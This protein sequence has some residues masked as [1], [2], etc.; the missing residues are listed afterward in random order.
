MRV[1]NHIGMWGS[2]LAW[3]SASAIHQIYPMASTTAFLE[4]TV[5]SLLDLAW[6]PRLLQPKQNF[7]N[8]LVTVKWSTLTALWL[9]FN[10]QTLVYC[11]Q[12][13]LNLSYKF[14]VASVA[15]FELVMH[16][17]PNKTTLHIHLCGFPITHNM[18]QCT[19]CQHTDYH[20]TTNNRENFPQLQLLQSHDT[21][22]N[23]AHTLVIQNFRLSLVVS[24]PTFVMKKKKKKKKNFLANNISTKEKNAEK[25]V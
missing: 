14:L 23:L 11:D 6:S 2:E 12:L 24:N 17:F 13:H 8:H 5:L 16:K 15:Q 7:P 20:D 21:C 19:T 18:K 1:T 3:Y 22:H 9:S 10:S 4:S 25:L